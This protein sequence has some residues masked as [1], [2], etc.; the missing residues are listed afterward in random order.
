MKRAIIAFLTGLVV[1]VSGLF[2]LKSQT[3]WN[4]RLVEQQ[5]QANRSSMRAGGND[6]DCG[7]AKLQ[8]S[9]QVCEENPG[10][11]TVKNIPKSC[12]QDQMKVKW[13]TEEGVKLVKGEEDNRQEVE[14]DTKLDLN[15]YK[16]VGVVPDGDG[17][18][19]D[20]KVEAKVT[21]TGDSCEDCGKAEATTDVGCSLDVTADSGSV[22]IGNT[23]TL[24][25][26]YNGCGTTSSTD[27]CTMNVSASGHTPNGNQFD[28]DTD[29][30]VD[31]DSVTFWGASD[32]E[33]IEVTGYREGTVTVNIGGGSGS[34][35]CGSES[36][37]IT[38][39]EN[40]EVTSGS[41]IKIKTDTKN[42]GDNPEGI[43]YLCKAKPGEY[44][45]KRYCW[46]KNHKTFANVDV[47]VNGG[48]KVDEFE[49]GPREH[50]LGCGESATRILEA[51]DDHT[52]KIEEQR[53]KFPKLKAESSCCG[54]D[55]TDKYDPD[56]CR[57]EL[58]KEHLLFCEEGDTKR[59]NAEVACDKARDC[60]VNSV[61]WSKPDVLE[62]INGGDGKD[63]ITLK[64]TVDRSI[65]KQL[66]T[67]KPT[68][69]GNNL[70]DCQNCKTDQVPVGVQ[71]TG[72]ITMEG[73]AE[74]HFDTDAN[75]RQGGIFNYNIIFDPG[76]LVKGGQIKSVKLTR[77]TVKLQQNGDTF[78]W[79]KGGSNTPETPKIEHIIIG[80]EHK[81][82][83]GD[84]D[85]KTLIPNKELLTK[86]RLRDDYATDIQ[87]S[88]SSAK[89]QLDVVVKAK[90]KV[91]TGDP[92]GDVNVGFDDTSQERS[93]A[94]YE[95]LKITKLPQY[96]FG[97]ADFWMPIKVKL[98]ETLRGR[99]FPEASE[100]EAN[101]IGVE[102]ITVQL[103]HRKKQNAK[104]ENELE[105]T[106]TKKSGTDENDDFIDETEDGSS[107]PT[108]T[109]KWGLGE[110]TTSAGEFTLAGKDFTI[111]GQGRANHKAITVFV[112]LKKLMKNSLSDPIAQTEGGN[113]IH[114]FSDNNEVPVPRFQVVVELSSEDE[115]TRSFA[116]LVEQN[117]E[118]KFL[119]DQ[120][121]GPVLE[122]GEPTEE[123]DVKFSSTNNYS[124]SLNYQKVGIDHKK[125]NNLPS[126]WRECNDQDEVYPLES[127]TF[128]VKGPGVTFRNLSAFSE[129]WE[130]TEGFVEGEG[131]DATL[132]CRNTP[133]ELEY[134]MQD[135]GIAEVRADTTLASNIP[136]D[137]WDNANNFGAL[138]QI[139]LSD[140]S[141]VS[142]GE[143]AQAEARAVTGTF[144][145]LSYGNN[146]NIKKIN[147]M[148]LGYTTIGV[149]IGEDRQ[150]PIPTKKL[151]LA[152]GI[153]TRNTE[154]TV[155]SASLALVGVVTAPF[156]LP[157][158]LSVGL[159]AF[160]AANTFYDVWDGAPTARASYRV[161]YRA[162]D[163]R[164]GDESA[165]ISNFY[166]NQ[167]IKRVND[168]KDKNRIDN[169]KVSIWGDDGQGSTTGGIEGPGFTHE[170][171]GGS[172]LTDG[173]YQTGP[174]SGKIDESGQFIAQSFSTTK[175]PGTRIDFE[176]MLFMTAE[177]ENS[178]LNKQ[179][180]ATLLMRQE[181]PYL[182]EDVSV[183]LPNKNN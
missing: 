172:K 155:L 77:L 79:L 7:D 171:E 156:N 62:T 68:K 31:T 60:S 84:V 29:Y 168:M 43:E 59:I 173:V 14:E 50:T 103:K 165:F 76:K 112:N 164:A 80:G 81:E 89:K 159:S 122:P 15:N 160:G 6:F 61:E 38:I 26:K 139:N 75:G 179:A 16:K 53:Q 46:G 118:P 85:Q 67:A 71:K 106:F 104:L 24:T 54:Q 127:T 91:T 146:Q 90:Y 58:D 175:K 11:A 64:N 157:T 135:F 100:D 42:T 1:S 86:R 57:V 133:D 98:P 180:A 28:P 30:D 78:P 36:K 9:D 10:I 44:T 169:A 49:D 123:N 115:L 153:S 5:P 66:I 102:E 73:P 114:L 8:V 154:Q 107:S 72:D 20:V 39:T 18:K 128:E 101:E 83:E 92:C 40:D 70:Y 23:A 22:K 149:D 182:L 82:I 176:M 162:Y 148:E 65:N 167:V 119:A 97:D 108:N 27:S 170:T 151:K 138:T 120:N 183:F 96:V 166:D 25:V 110:G 131:P 69:E 87:V 51:S 2:I 177:V 161:E 143:R 140:Y 136:G 147:V 142:T 13:S 181:T 150:G 116:S 56:L 55:T 41:D 52:Q 130:L 174:D 178:T 105:A 17:G 32:K 93:T 132:K 95:G 109:V 145:Y 47:S 111:Q 4:G 34:C 88:F 152:S 19:Q 113:P 125:T 137:I 63:F 35:N 12:N 45:L 117:G 37:S 48:R 144:F 21:G 158:S 129:T 141:S 74:D 126:Y 33:K 163:T 124:G 99:H 134:G 3:G 94:I 121:V